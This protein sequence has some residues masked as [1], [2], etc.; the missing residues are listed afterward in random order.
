MT[1]RSK[2]LERSAPPTTPVMWRMTC[3][4]LRP[5]QRAVVLPMFT[6]RHRH[7]IERVGCIS[8]LPE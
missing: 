4:A 7:E 8:R 1:H 6:A 3:I 5:N 2:F